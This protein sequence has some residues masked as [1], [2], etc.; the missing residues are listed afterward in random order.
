MPPDAGAIDQNGVIP[1]ASTRLSYRDRAGLCDWQ[2][3]RV[4]AYLSIR[5]DSAVRVSDLAAEVKLSPSH[6]A[7]AFTIRLGLSPYSFIMKLRIE[8]ASALL[9]NSDKSLTEIAFNCGLSD[10]AHFSRLFR[11][12]VGMTPT[13]WRRKHLTARARLSSQNDNMGHGEQDLLRISA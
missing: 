2:F 5:I 8:R 7:R 12:F 9:L 1:S 6:F 13:Q 10:Q 11:R 3:K 4:M